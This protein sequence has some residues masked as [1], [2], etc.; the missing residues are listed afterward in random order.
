MLNGHHLDDEPLLAGAADAFN[1]HG[2]RTRWHAAIFCTGTDG[3]I[4]R[5]SEPNSAANG[6]I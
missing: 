2:L 3:G 1:F 6:P 4:G 5:A